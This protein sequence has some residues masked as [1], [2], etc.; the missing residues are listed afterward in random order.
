MKIRM[1]RVSVAEPFGLHLWF[2]PECEVVSLRELTDDEKAVRL[3]KDGSVSALLNDELHDGISSS[4]LF[5]Q[6]ELPF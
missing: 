1:W 4:L 2:D 3:D 5:L 6:E